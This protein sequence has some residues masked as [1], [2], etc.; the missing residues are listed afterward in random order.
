MPRPGRT[1][2][3]SISLDPEAMAT[4][5]ARAKRVAGG[6]LSAAVADALRVAKEQ[7]GRE[8]LVAW[9]RE[10]HG[11]PTDEERAAIRAEW[12]EALARPV[13]AAPSAGERRRVAKRSP[14]ER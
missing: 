3:I 10:V 8:A 6:N 1:S 4:L 2:K 14:A 9:L 12:R 13:P 5:E 11:E 7:E